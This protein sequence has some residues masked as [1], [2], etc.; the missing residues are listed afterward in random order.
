MMAVSRRFNQEIGN[1]ELLWH[2]YLKS[3]RL[4]E[5]KKHNY[6]FSAAFGSDNLEGL[7]EEGLQL[8]PHG[9]VYQA[10]KAKIDHYPRMIDKVNILGLKAD[11][12]NI[13]RIILANSHFR[14]ILLQAGSLGWHAAFKMS[15]KFDNKTMLLGF[16]WLYQ[17]EV[18]AV[19]A[20]TPA[21]GSLHTLLA[22]GCYEI[23]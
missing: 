15:L 3:E 5:I 17:P 4:E 22:I 18:L 2:P 7:T 8:H 21:D 20:P 19:L 14:E 1:K 23:T 13:A 12:R 11:D 10:L 16:E 9:P 6:S